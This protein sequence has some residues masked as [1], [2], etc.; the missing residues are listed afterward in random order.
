MNTRSLVA[1]LAA[2]FVVFS[3]SAQ[4]FGTAPLN[5]AFKAHLE[6]ARA[7]EGAFTDSGRPLGYLPP[8]STFAA[9]QP[10]DHLFAGQPRAPAS[11]DLRNHNKVSSVQ[12]QGRYGNCW[13]FATFG[14]LESCI[15]PNDTSRFSENNLAY[16]HGFDWVYGEGGNFMM[17]MAYLGRWAGPVRLDA[18]P[19]DQQRRPNLSP[20]KHVQ[21]MFIAP[22]RSSSTDNEL[23]KQMLMRYGAL[24]FTYYHD[25]SYAK[26]GNYYFNGSGKYGNH[27]VTLIGWDDNYA[28]S[29]FKNTPPGNGAWLIRN[30]WGTSWGQSGYGWI[31]YYDSV[32]GREESAVFPAAESA[33]NYARAFQYDTLGAISWYGYYSPLAYGANI[34]TAGGSG[35]FIRAVSFYLGAANSTFKIWVFTDVTPG[36]PTSGTCVSTT[37]GSCTFAGYITIP[38]NNGLNVSPGKSFSVVVGFNS[39]GLNFP[40][41][42]ESAISGYSS[43]AVIEPNVS[44]F[45][46]D[47]NSWE[48]GG[49]K[50]NAAIKAFGDNTANQNP[51]A[52]DAYIYA[53]YGAYYTELA[54]NY[55]WR[56]DYYNF[57]YAAYYY[58]YYAHQ[59]AYYAFVYNYYY[60]DDFGYAGSAYMYSHAAFQNAWNA[61]AYSTGDVYSYYGAVYEQYAYVYSYMTATGQR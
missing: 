55:Y 50:Y 44:Y 49:N 21:Y 28:A 16:Y 17:S 48:N 40:V 9:T 18:D 7:G 41:P 33:S 43:R 54:Y 20:S 32:A 58:A 24:F 25:D 39:P 31:S 26:G 29:N 37:E 45:S 34:F 36:Y 56:Y 42:A 23:L 1:L 47:G 38:F 13:T 11:Y 5:P 3:V 14:S 59:Y 12:D 51:R 2:V 8:P 53:Y 57:L 10:A 52:Y 46:S 4:E 35:A 61:Y 30:S 6:R 19:Y 22:P 15:R 27:A 60:G